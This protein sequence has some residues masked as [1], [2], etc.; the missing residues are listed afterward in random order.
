MAEHRRSD[1][2][3]TCDRCGRPFEKFSR[4]ESEGLHIRR[5]ESWGIGLGG[6]CGAVHIDI[7]LCGR[8]APE[9]RRFMAGEAIE[10]VER[11]DAQGQEV[12]ER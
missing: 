12:N 3:Y 1:V 5:A 9:H 2:T 8:C 10:E 4:V 6:G 11:E 7:D